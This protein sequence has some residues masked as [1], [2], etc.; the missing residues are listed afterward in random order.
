MSGRTDACRLVDDYLLGEP[1]SKPVVIAALLAAPSESAAAAPFYRAFEAVGVRAAD[2]ALIAL[3]LVLAG[4]DASDGRVRRLRALARLA[5]CA[6][7]GD[8]AGVTAALERDRRD[9]SDVVVGGALLDLA[10]IRDAAKCAY[11]AELG[12]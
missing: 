7:T 1:V 5:G 6:V 8:R 10:A 12:E 4:Q 9:L 3:R 2:E 11:M